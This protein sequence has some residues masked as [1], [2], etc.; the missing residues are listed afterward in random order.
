MYGNGVF[1]HGIHGS[2]NVPAR[3]LRRRVLVGRE[4]LF[5]GV[6]HDGA[7]GEWGPY[8]GFPVNAAILRRRITP[9]RHEPDPEN[10]PSFRST[11]PA[12]PPHT[13]SLKDFSSIFILQGAAKPS[14]WR[15]SCAAGVFQKYVYRI[16]PFLHESPGRGGKTGTTE[17]DTGPDWYAGETV[18]AYV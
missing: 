5:W 10:R 13:R 9:L 12:P 7:D 14:D 6:W 16:P 18:L 1:L 2:G 3:S 4:Y 8:P 11:P 17:P 15:K